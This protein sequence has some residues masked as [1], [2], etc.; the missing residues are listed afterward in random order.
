MTGQE[1]FFD[2]EG[3]P[4][5]NVL[6]TGNYHMMVDS[7]VDKTARSGKRM[8]ECKYTV[9]APESHAGLVYFEYL[10]LGTDEAPTAVVKTAMGTRFF[11]QLCK[12][13]QMA[14]ATSVASLIAGLMQGKAQFML[15]AMFKVEPPE[16]E[17]A[18]QEG[19]KTIKYMRLGEME[20]KVD[21]EAPKAAGPLPAAVPPGTVAPPV[22]PVAP[23]APA[24]PAAPVAPVAPVAPPAP[25]APAA[26]TVPVAPVAPVVPPV[27][28]AAPAAGVQTIA[29]TLCGTVVAMADL[30]T[31]VNSPECQAAAAARNAG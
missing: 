3:T 8:L 20:P 16:S 27:A 22:A 23:V 6:P 5:S 2:W 29:C 9:V 15:R 28:N 26:P 24:A 12:A 19:N 30:A 17:Y 10:T 13:A 1:D 18:G 4:D 14:P 11:K 21:P 25:V 7:I 31:H